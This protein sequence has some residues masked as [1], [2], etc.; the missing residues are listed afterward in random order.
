MSEDHIVRS[1]DEE[2]ARLQNIISQMGGMAESQLA[3]AIRA[4]VKRD[5]EVAER[6]VA[7]DER[8]DRLEAE[9]HDF[10]VRLLALRQ[11]MADDLRA[12]IAA[13]K[14]SN[15]LERIGDL[16][17]NIAKRALT[18]NQIPPIKPVQS[19]PHMAAIVEEIVKD[20]L[21]AYCES[22]T[23]KATAVWNRDEEV[24]DMYNS[25]FRELLTYMMEDPRYITA[26]A[27]L[28]FIAK[29]IER[30]GDHATN[31][32]ETIHFLVT[33]R[34]LDATVRPKDDAAS[35]TLVDARSLKE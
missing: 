1:F 33:G 7:A 16:A 9:V 29:N 24:D 20:V 3:A 27:H 10:T 19:V 6:V 14:I 34:A 11:P 23:D 8:L 12:I 22:N 17:K 35:F 21:D 15:D 25:L 26:C 2:L 13:L 30:I 5:S 18:L 4:I 28:L 31:I 32:A